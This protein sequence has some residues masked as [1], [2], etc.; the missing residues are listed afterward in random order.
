METLKKIA[1]LVPKQGMSNDDFQRHWQLVHGP[2]VAGSPGYARWRL[3]YVQ[4]HVRGPGPVGRHFGYSGMAEFSLPGRSP[5]ED[6]FAQ[7]STYRDHIAPDERNFVDMERTVSMTALEDTVLPG[8]APAKLVVLSRRANG[9]AADDLRR[10]YRAEVVAGAMAQPGFARRIRGW[11]VNHVIEGSFRLPGG[12][13]VQGLTV[14][15][16]EE[17]WFDSPD[18]LLVA[19]ASLPLASALLDDGS[20]QSFVGQEHVFFDDGQVVTDPASI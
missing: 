8:H 6:A 2:L 18:E 16:V 11:C 13:A 20:R 3:R 14:D 5:N 17:L 19:F 4:N 7:T 12:R 10:R 1:F 15:L 9:V